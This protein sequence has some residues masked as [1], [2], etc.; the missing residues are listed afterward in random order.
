LTFFLFGGVISFI[1]FVF[2]TLP[3][4]KDVGICLSYVL[5]LFPPYLFGSTLIDITSAKIFALVN[6]SNSE[7]I[8]LYDW[9]NNG[10][11]IFFYI[12]DFIF[13]TTILFFFEYL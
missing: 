13:L 2:K 8:N 7:N 3:K 4:V 9:Q 10:Q 12:I 6:G 5:K 11:N 1:I